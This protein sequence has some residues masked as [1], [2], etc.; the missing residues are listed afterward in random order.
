M[1]LNAPYV[2]SGIRKTTQDVTTFT[3]K[4]QNGGSIDFTPGMFAMLT[5]NNPQSGEKVSRAFSMANSPPSDSLEFFISMIGGKLTSKLAEAKLGDLYYISAPYG[6]FKF[7]L[8]SANK[9]LFLAGGTGLAPF[10]SMLEYIIANGAKPDIVLIYS[11]KYPYDIIE[12]DRL[13]DMITKLGGKVVITVTRPKP[14][15]NWT[16]E[17]GHADA[18]LIKKHAPDFAQRVS[19]IC[20]PPAFVKALKDG[21]VGL[22]VPEKEIRAEMW[23]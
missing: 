22:G 11:V 9:L 13:N 16:G 14:E 8:K 21:L 2:I 7:D 23:G 4:A 10:F 1:I 12:K 3:F 5:Y 18:N 19:Y 15:D 20:G 6:Q 17:T